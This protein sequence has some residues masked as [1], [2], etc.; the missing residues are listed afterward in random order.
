MNCSFKTHQIIRTTRIRRS[1][2][3][4]QPTQQKN[5]WKP[6]KNR[7]RVLYTKLH[8][9]NRLSVFANKNGLPTYTCDSWKRKSI[10]LFCLGSA[11]CIIHSYYFDVI[12]TLLLFMSMNICK[13]FDNKT[14][15]KRVLFAFIPPL[16]IHSQLCC[17]FEISQ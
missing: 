6:T 4:S 13:P 8:A 2:T 5:L 10:I 15:D 17:V 3:F 7:W 11:S 16:K 12:L 9:V 1:N 14:S